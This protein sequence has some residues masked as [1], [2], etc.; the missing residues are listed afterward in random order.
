MLKQS[1][2]FNRA[3]TE[4]AT[5]AIITIKSHG[6]VLTWNRAAERIFGYSSDDMKNKKLTKIMPKQYK[7]GH[8]K[9]VERL[10]SGGN[11]KL[12]GKT[13]EIVAKKKMELNFLSSFHYQAG[14]WTIK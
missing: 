7:T 3:I 11:K 10:G 6:N 13:V 12:I 4:T 2:K 5:D 8:N 1:E 14:V 9:G